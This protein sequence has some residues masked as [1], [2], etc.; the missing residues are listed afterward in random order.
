M[1]P[2][3]DHI[4]RRPDV[5]R[6][7][8]EKRVNWTFDP[9]VPLDEFDKEASLKN[10][11]RFTPLDSR[12]VEIYTAAMERG[13]QF[14]AVIAYR[15]AGKRGLVM[16]D[17]NHRFHAHEGSSHTT[18][19]TYILKDVSPEMVAVL[20]YLFNGKHGLPSSEEDRAA[21]A[22]FLIR[23]GATRP[24]AAAVVGL[25]EGTVGRAWAKD[26]ADRRAADVGV[27]NWQKLSPSNRIRLSQ[28]HTDG[29]F[30]E[31]TRLAVDAVLNGKQIA[32]MVSE[33][34]KT[35]SEVKQVDAVKE[36]ADVVKPQIDATAGGVLRKRGNPQL[37]PKNMFLAHCGFFEKMDI[38][39]VLTATPD[40][41]DRKTL[42]ERA[43]ATVE[44][45]SKYAERL[46]E[47]Q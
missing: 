45:L 22:V 27:K 13:D 39:R 14:P 33:V 19:P 29:G 10:Q 32:E 5:E 38:E 17:G 9:E 18:V 7:L 6:D 34:N 31:A 36:Y 35:R 47:G 21:H 43:D 4:A 8:D 37:A 46:R 1:A 44:R 41:E 12:T 15:R 40:I 16:I 20:T 2:A 25:P 26:Q 42:A 24:A 28:V 11:A 23:N 3:I 30:V